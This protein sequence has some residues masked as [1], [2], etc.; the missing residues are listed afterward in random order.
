M[1]AVTKSLETLLD[2]VQ[3]L[4]KFHDRPITYLY[5]T[6]HYYDRLL[7]DRPTL[8]KKLVSSIFGALREVR[9]EGWFVTPDY[10]E[11]IEKDSKAAANGGVPTPPSA[12]ADGGE[13]WTPSRGY[14]ARLIGRMAKAMR[15]QQQAFPK[16]DWRFNEFPNEGAH[17]LYV[18]CVEIMALPSK[19]PPHVCGHLLEVLLDHG[20]L[21]SEEDLPD[22]VNAV[23]LIISYLPEAY[24]EGLAQRLV[25]AINSPPLSQCPPGGATSPDSLPTW[26]FNLFTPEGARESA[27]S[28]FFFGGN[29]G[30][31]SSSSD[32]TNR[33]ASKLNILLALAHAVYHHCG[34]FNILS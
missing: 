8:R 24:W 6:L 22:W 25:G 2:H 11:Y 1:P 5:N 9:P 29:S 34:Q 19:E 16:M 18:T 30:S 32:D 3:V 7:R 15:G 20:N 13:Q 12:P 4:Y 21:L 14:Y 23:G 26:P 28:G 17:A 27:A 33:N 31:S 10:I